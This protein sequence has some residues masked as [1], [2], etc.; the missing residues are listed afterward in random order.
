[1]TLLLVHA[2]HGYA[3]QDHTIRPFLM[4][5]T[6]DARQINTETAVLTNN[7]PHA[8]L[9]F[10][11]TVNEI[12]IDK[13][14]EIKEFISP[15]MTDR[16]NTVTSWIEVKRSRIEVNPGESVEVPITVRVNPFAQPGEYYAFVGFVPTSNRP[17]AEA[18][19]MKGEA[20]GV[21]LKI[22]IA[23]NRSDSM[24][25]SGFLIERFITNDEKRDI[26]VVIENTGEL[27]SAPQGEIIFYDSRGVE[28]NA[29]PFNEEG[30]VIEP[31]E[32]K[33]LTGSVPLDENLGRFKAN[34]SLTYGTNQ[35][36]SLF[37]SASF[38]LMP[39]H[40][41]L[42][43]FAAILVTIIV[44]TLLLRRAFSTGVID[45]EHGEEVIM[46]VREGNHDPEPKD[47]D[48]NLKPKE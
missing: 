29:T 14:G 7:E 21:I 2:S 1:M 37:D 30:V 41:L 31:G 13:E 26:E 46:F 38:Y 3:A 6:L 35:A 48:I 25:I 15:V 36:A 9:R 22:T 44:I 5:M 11:A 16:T 33:T 20:D 17:L 4:D 34:I 45:D 23:D 43:V 28:I 39:I 24:K 12:S 18:A 10:F 8:K 32:S 47:H 42:A 27:P 40:M 19:A